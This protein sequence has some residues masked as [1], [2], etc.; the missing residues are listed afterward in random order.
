MDVCTEPVHWLWPRR[1]ACGK[2][3]IIA[4]HPGLGESQISASLAAIVSTDSECECF[5]LAG[6]QYQPVM[7]TDRV[8]GK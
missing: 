3:T 1:I 6:K 4:G 5:G 8:L 7:G 2:V